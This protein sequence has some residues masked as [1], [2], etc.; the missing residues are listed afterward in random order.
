MGRGGVVVARGESSP[1][2]GLLH[3]Q[4]SNISINTTFMS[5][6]EMDWATRQVSM[7]ALLIPQLLLMLLF[8]CG[9]RVY[10]E[11]AGTTLWG[12]VLEKK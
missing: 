9:R 7:A 12:R 2:R 11:R 4:Y 6:T 3:T 10:V 1:A 5:R 8:V